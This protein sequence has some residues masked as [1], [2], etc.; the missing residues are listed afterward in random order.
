MKIAVCA[1]MAFAK[2]LLELDAQLKALGHEVILPPNTE[3]FLTER[4]NERD[5]T[6]DIS[7]EMKS[8][9]ASIETSD[10]IL[11]PNYP[12]NGIDGYVWWCTLMEITIA[13]YLNKKI[14]ILYPLPTKD[15]LRYVQEILLTMPI[16]LDG[17][18]G[19]IG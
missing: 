5:I 14:F 8:H 16:I 2:E 7:D 13:F 12:K 15:Q 18:L 4:N 1:S 19:K 10:A 3:N 6:K 9:Y 17:D 11:I